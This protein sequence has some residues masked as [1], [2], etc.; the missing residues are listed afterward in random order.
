M[1]SGADVVVVGACDAEVVDGL[2]RAGGLEGGDFGGGAVGS[3]EPVA[4]V[5][6][7]GGGEALVLDVE[8]VVAGGDEFTGGGGHAQGRDLVVGEGAFD[9]AGGVLPGVGV[10]GG[11]PVAFGDVLDVLGGAVGHEDLGAGA[12]TTDL[13]DPGDL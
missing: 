8:G 6:P 12:E 4:L 11:D 3:A 7:A 13:G 2:G 1:G 9:A 5:E 10:G